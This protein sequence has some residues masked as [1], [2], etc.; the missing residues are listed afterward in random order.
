MATHK[1]ESK[2]SKGKPQSR[3]VL[4]QPARKGSRDDHLQAWLNEHDRGRKVR[5]YPV[6]RL[7]EEGP[8]YGKWPQAGDEVGYGMDPYRRDD[9]L[10]VAIA[11]VLQHPIEQVPDLHLD[12]RIKAGESP[13]EVS[14]SSW[15]RIERWLDALELVLGMH[16]EPP[17]N[18]SRWIGVCPDPAGS[19]MLGD[20]CLVM[21]H[22]QL[23]F[24][25]SVSLKCPPGTQV[26][27][28][29]PEDISYGISFNRKEQ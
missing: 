13:R 5:A 8:E 22:H 20:H 4:I 29:D 18:R 23:V 7:T 9:C 3:R 16:V 17:L 15:E 28:F 11:T 12:E 27:R 14:D 21:S 25:P 1:R 19:W 2:G 26:R 6:V 24:D 10:T